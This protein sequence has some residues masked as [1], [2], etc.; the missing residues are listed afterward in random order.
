MPRC[1]R[2]SSSSCSWWCHTNSPSSFAHFT[3][4]PFSS[5]TTCGSQWVVMRA[6]APERSTVFNRG[7]FTGD[8]RYGNADPG[9]AWRACTPG[10]AG[11]VGCV[12][13]ERSGVCHRRVRGAPMQE[14]ETI[15]IVRP[16]LPG[17]TE[18]R[19]R[20][21]SRRSSMSVHHEQRQHL[22]DW[23][24]SVLSPPKES[25]RRPGRAGWPGLRTD[26]SHRAPRCTRRF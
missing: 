8:R 16:P 25:T 3:N 23:K 17:Y 19:R 21:P 7:T 10:R 6:K 24:Q 11:R 5:P 18:R 26:R 20:A 12:L 4:C 22:R 1:T 2:N 9:T 14:W 15:T 13:R